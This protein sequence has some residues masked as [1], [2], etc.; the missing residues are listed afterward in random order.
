M[1]LSDIA[2]SDMA[3]SDMALTVQATEQPNQ[4]NNWQR[5][6]DKPKQ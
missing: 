4:K 2:L 3:L 1:A 5:N 6:A